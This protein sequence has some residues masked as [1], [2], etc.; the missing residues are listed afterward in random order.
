[1]FHFIVPVPLMDRPLLI[2]FRTVEKEGAKVIKSSL[3]LLMVQ[4]APKS[5]Q[6]ARSSENF[7]RRE[8]D[9]AMDCQALK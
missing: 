4:L 6:M 9:A 5:M 3:Q 2:P 1:M 8:L 7:M